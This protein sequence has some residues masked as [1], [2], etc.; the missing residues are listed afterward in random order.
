[1]DRKR[2]GARLR[3]ILKAEQL[4]S[5]SMLASLVGGSPWQNPL[6][7]N[8]LDFDGVVSPGDAL[9][10]INMLNA[11]RS[12]DLAEKFA[13]PQLHGHFQN[14]ASEFLDADGDGSL[15]AGDALAVIN[16]LN[17]GQPWL[18]HHVPDVDQ[19]ETIGGAQEL[20]VTHGF[21][22]MR[23]VITGSTDV[24]F[25]KVTAIKSELNVA[26][27]SR[28]EGAFG[29]SIVDATGKVLASATIEAGSYR[30]AKL[31]LDVVAETTYYVKVTGDGG[32]Y[33]VAVLNFDEHSFLP[34]PDSELGDDQ[35]GDTV[36]TATALTLNHGFARVVSN[37]DSG[38]DADMFSLTAVDGK[39]IVEADADFS[40]DVE[41]SGPNGS[42][43]AFT[44]SERRVIVLNVTAGTYQITVTGSNSSDMGAYRLRVG[45]VPLP[46]PGG[47]PHPSNSPPRRIVKKLFDK[48]DADGSGLVTRPEIRAVV[49]GGPLRIADHVFANWDTND[50]QALSL[51]EV[52]TGLATLPSAIPNRSDHGP[53]APLVTAR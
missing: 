31:N 30:P 53:V 5:R 43:D 40:L 46:E 36:Q 45:N 16:V 13:P 11:G 7:P 52:I 32:P 23:G 1:M 2:R 22:R 24:D 50:D 49:G 35:H 51:D 29:V 18:G 48:V 10:A 12:G 27:F 47:D 8:D 37:I 3:R 28:S 15:S 21:A 9:A 33:A 20:D 44:T 6:D 4:E 26:L 19:G 34:Q 41:I 38:M 25:F 14:A 42:L 39:L 17:S